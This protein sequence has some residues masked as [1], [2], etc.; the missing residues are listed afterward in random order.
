M[1]FFSEKQI[2]GN[3][4]KYTDTDRVVTRKNTSNENEWIN[5]R[6]SDETSYIAGLD[7]ARTCTL[8]IRSYSIVPCLSVPCLGRLLRVRG[9]EEGRRPEG[10][11]G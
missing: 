11:G 8:C 10:D 9:R 3:V 5:K 6:S 7:G 4:M 1:I 2:R